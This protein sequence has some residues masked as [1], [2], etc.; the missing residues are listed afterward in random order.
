MNFRKIERKNQKDRNIR[1]NR[2]LQKLSW[3]TLRVKRKQSEEPEG[4]KRVQ[5]EKKGW[6]Q[7]SHRT[8]ERL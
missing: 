1:R 3:E 7:L 5:K 8:R 2:K 6:V 4:R